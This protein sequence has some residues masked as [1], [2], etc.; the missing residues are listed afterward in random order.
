M[1]YFHTGPLCISSGQYF[2]GK[3]NDIGGGSVVA[4]FANGGH[5]MYSFG[6]W[7]MGYGIWD[8]GLL[9]Q[10]GNGD[11]IFTSPDHIRRYNVTLTVYHKHVFGSVVL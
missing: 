11:G 10:Y 2:N 5:G 4:G 7:D 8:M 3:D 6:I 1:R 9:V